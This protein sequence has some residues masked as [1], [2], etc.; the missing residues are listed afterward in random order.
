MD[1]NIHVPVWA[2]ILQKKNQNSKFSFIKGPL[3]D[4]VDTAWVYYVHYV[5]LVIM[6]LLGFFKKIGWIIC[7]LVY[8]F[9]YL[10][11]MKYL[12]HV[13]KCNFLIKNWICDSIADSRS[14]LT[15]L[16]IFWSYGYVCFEKSYLSGEFWLMMRSNPEYLICR[17]HQFISSQRQRDFQNFLLHLLLPFS[18]DL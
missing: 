14:L 11:Y 8:M 12:I 5:H 17:F 1:L 13:D 2:C 7:S 3:R 18:F 6:S 4:S 15:S 9:C 10:T 16:N